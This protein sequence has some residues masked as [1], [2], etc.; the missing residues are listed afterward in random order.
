[1]ATQ[2]TRLAVPSTTAKVAIPTRTMAGASIYARMFRMVIT[3]T[4]GMGSDRIRAIHWIASTLTSAKATTRAPKC[5]RTQR[6]GND[7]ILSSS[8]ISYLLFQGSYICKCVDDYNSGVV[9][10][11]MTG[12]D[13]RA[14]GEPALVMVAANDKILQLNMVG[15]RGRVNAAARA[16]N[17]ESDIGAVEFDPR[18]ELMF[19]VDTFQKRVFRS[20]LPKGNQSVKWQN[21]FLNQFL[22]HEGQ[23]L[24]V[25]FEDN[26]SPMS[27]A[28]DYLTGYV[29]QF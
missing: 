22:Q 15:P 13:C 23:E 16:A 9:I 24:L 7:F 27:M 20:A 29:L 1:M 5:A 12:K 17:K 28:V 19:W 2:P 8:F 25:R 3:A 14:N 18:R 6:W 4:A 10:G 11:A 26:I 21:L